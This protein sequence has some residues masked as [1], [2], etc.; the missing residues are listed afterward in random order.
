VGGASGLGDRIHW[1]A[2]PLGPQTGPATPAEGSGPEFA[3]RGSSALPKTGSKAPNP[4]LEYEVVASLDVDGRTLEAKLPPTTFIRQDEADILRQEYL[5]YGT[6]F[7]PALANVSV[8]GRPTFNRGN[9]TLIV[10]Q[11][12]G[13][14]D[15]LLTDVEAEVNREL[16]DDV[17]VVPPGTQSLSP[18][19]VVVSPGPPV[20][21]V[22]PL[23]DTEPQGD[24]VCAGPRVNNGC[25]GRILA[26]RNG[27]ADTVANNRKTRVSLDLIITS[28]Y[29]NPQRN[30]FIGSGTVNS[31]HTIGKALDLDPR[32]LV[33][34]MP[35]KS[36]SQL[37]CVVEQAGARVLGDDN[38]FTENGPV[39]FLE[40]DDPAA[41]HVHVQR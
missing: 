20:M 39:T 38:S 6:K 25:A 3:F 24:D 10:E 15:K 26:G 32:M 27:I 9:Y 40:C 31:R 23:G 17:Q 21:F 30:K 36:G 4:P 34:S 5:D 14:L 19:A 28:A 2:R 13:E 1:T 8:A 18:V 22:G 29:R 16:N 41:D 35:G 7:Q 37:M 11:S 12:P 33:A